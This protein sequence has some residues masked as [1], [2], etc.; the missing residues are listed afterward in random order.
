MIFSFDIKNIGKWSE[1][2]ILIIPAKQFV[3]RNMS[4]SKYG[5]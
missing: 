3:F 2:S 5:Q 4:W 1:M